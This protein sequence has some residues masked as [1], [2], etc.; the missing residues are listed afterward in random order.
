VSSDSNTPKIQRIKT[1]Q[2]ERRSSMAKAGAVASAKLAANSV[3]S[4]FVGKEKR[5]QRRKNA[6]NKQ[7]LYLVGQLG[8]LKGSVVKV[9]Q[10]MALYGEHFLPDEITTALHTLED[11]TVALEWSA[12]QV[13]IE[14]QLGDKIHEFDIDPDP[15]GAASLAQVH[16]ATRKSDGRKLCIKVQYPGVAAAID[17]D[18]EAMTGLLKLTKMVP[19]GPDFDNW[20]DEIRTMLH[21]EVDYLAESAITERFRQRLIDDPRFVVPEV[22]S[23]YSSSQIMVMSWEEGVEVTSDAAAQLPQERR[24]QIALSLLDL[25]FNEF[26]SWK[27]L[28]TDPN[29]GNYR[30]RINDG[31]NDQLVLLDF[32]AVRA[33]PDHFIDA[34]RD[35]AEGAF[36]R[37]QDQVIRGGVALNFMRADTPPDVLES[38]AK[39]AFR[40]MEPFV[41]DQHSPVPEQF[42]TDSGKYCWSAS[43]LPKR[44]AGQAGGAALSR[45]FR[46]PP[47][48]F[49][50]FIR[51]LVGVYTFVAVVG[52]EINAAPLLDQWL[53]RTKPSRID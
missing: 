6:L 24:N 35:V 23:E 19:R 13:A 14:E 33:F 50:F 8:E 2:F 37:D 46:V 53:S 25:F 34:F 10:M 45:H 32:G 20:L 22:L 40:V 11:K 9:G 29:F 27:E 21:Q 42:Q 12:I 41:N 16:R 18:I 17:S 52:A 39:V 28:Q 49:L 31:G 1:G 38:F 48:E 4:L 15:I 44:I 3:G 36:K 51:K 7:T 5:K 26:L 43:D 47:Q 30:I